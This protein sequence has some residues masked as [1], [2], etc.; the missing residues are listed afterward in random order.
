VPVALS[1]YRYPSVHR[2][3]PWAAFLE[4]C[5][6]AMPQVYWLGAHNA[7]VQLARCVREYGEARLVGTVRPVV[8]TGSAWAQSDW[9]PTTGDLH[10][11][12][13]QA[14][15]LKLTAANFYSWDGATVPDHRDLW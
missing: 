5:D 3:L 14:Q 8:P 9:A 2:T 12:L 10:K 7:D 4:R 11:F 6:L 15:K 1:S 13:D